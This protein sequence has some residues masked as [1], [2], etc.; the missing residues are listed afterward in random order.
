M[1]NTKEIQVSEKTA[2]ILS[3]INEKT[4]LGDL[5][6][7][8]K[9]IKTDHE[10]AMSL[11][12]SGQYLPRRLSIL[13]MD[14]K[15]LNEDSID[16][17]IMDMEIHPY[18]ERL[19][20][21]DWLMANQLDKSKPLTALM[22]T[23]EDSKSPLQRRVFW[24]HQGRLRWTGKPGPEN[25]DHLIEQIEKNLMKEQS[26]VQWAMNFTAGWIGVYNPEYRARCVQIGLDSGLYKDD[27][28]SKGCTPN[29][30]PEFIAIEA[31]KR[32]LDTESEG[33]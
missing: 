19:Q 11:W 2:E 27:V 26:E 1:T 24:Y 31:E 29:Y 21:V 16:Q 13:L 8:A 9:E 15:Q 25:T 4:K 7:I 20:L 17:L 3:R 18:D 33:E 10:L 14:K 32:N 22:E 5:R 30:L 12:A 28:V 6:K 23:W